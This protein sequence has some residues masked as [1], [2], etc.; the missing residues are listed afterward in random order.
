MRGGR[1]NSS[2]EGGKRI[3]TQF[4][5]TEEGE[6]F[7]IEGINYLSNPNREKLRRIVQEV[8]CRLRILR[9]DGVG[10]M[11]GNWGEGHLIH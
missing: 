1:V 9:A 5:E 6:N 11:K 8:L 2:W 10:F 7:K 3:R 4:K